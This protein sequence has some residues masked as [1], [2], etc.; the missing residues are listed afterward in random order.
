MK[1]S[2]V[3]TA[4]VIALACV[5]FTSVRYYLDSRLARATATIQ[6]SF[7]TIPA[8]DGGGQ[9]TTGSGLGQSKMNDPVELSLDSPEVTQAAQEAG[10]TANG[11]V[12]RARLLKIATTEPIRGTNSLEIVV[13]H[14]SR[15]HAI[16]LANA[17]ANAAVRIQKE[18]NQKRIK[19][20][21]QALKTELTS[22]E[23]HL[24]IQGQ[25]LR[26]LMEEY[27]LPIPKLDHPFPNPNNIP[28]FANEEPTEYST[29]Q[30]TYQKSLKAYQ[31]SKTT[32]QEITTRYPKATAAILQHTTSVIVHSYAR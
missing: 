26:S 12:D 2:F 6:I 7:S 15:P 4:I 1:R 32:L 3:I 5:I 14:E 16:A 27:T 13:K 20:R 21:L 24:E 29:R 11:E 28:K 10:I 19:T 17:F 23:K 9:I 22:P 18:H 25:E 30:E 31:E 8:D